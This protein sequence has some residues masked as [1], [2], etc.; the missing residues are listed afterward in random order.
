MS[1]AAGGLGFAFFTFTNA[2][3]ESGVQIVLD[4]TKLETYMK[5]ADLIITGEGC[6]DEQTAMGKA[7][8]GV[9]RLAKKFQKPV[10]AF[11]GTVTKEAVAC[12]K[13]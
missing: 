10:L 7:P 13:V 1:G 3:L 4:E 5:D 2:V 12:N 8:I 11:A 6:L 9:A